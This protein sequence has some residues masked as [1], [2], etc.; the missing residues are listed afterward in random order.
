[1]NDVQRPHEENAGL[2][3][4]LGADRD[5]LHVLVDLALHRD[6]PPQQLGRDLGSQYEIIIPEVADPDDETEPPVPH[7]DG[8]LV[9]KDDRLAPVPRSGQ[10]G[11][12]QAHH[13]GLND[14]A[15]H[16]LEGHDDHGL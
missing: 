9:A 10:L 4:R 3:G 1:M 5:V 8:G 13:E 12:D 2:V 14:A 16:C 7:G 15:Q 6:P 11:E